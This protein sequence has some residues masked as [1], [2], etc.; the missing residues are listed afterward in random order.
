MSPMHPLSDEVAQLARFVMSPTIGPEFLATIS[1]V[2]A[3]LA[4]VPHA[5]IGGQAVFFRGYRRFSKDVD[6]G[7]S[8]TV[9]EAVK[10]LAAAGFRVVEGARLVDPATKIEVDVVHLPRA[11]IPR[12]RAT[13]PIDLGGG[14]RARVIDVESL[15]AL[16]VKIG[17]LQDEADVVELLKAGARPDRGVVVDLLKRLGEGSDTYDRLV[18]RASTEQA[19]PLPSL[20]EDDGGDE[21]G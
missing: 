1:R 10:L 3:A 5:L 12:L 7:V 21:R 2:T 18:A 4:S 11:V 6:V 16:K 9:R 8:T 19:A 17:R 13:D 14:V 20:D 15:V